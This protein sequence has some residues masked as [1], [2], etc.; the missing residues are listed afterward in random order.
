MFKFYEKERLLKFHENVNNKFQGLQYKW[1]ELPPF[2]M[3]SK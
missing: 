3:F 1:F 2:M